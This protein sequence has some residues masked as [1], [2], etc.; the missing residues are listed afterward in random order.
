MMANPPI[1]LLEHDYA[2]SD[3]IIRD[4]EAL[5]ERAK[6]RQLR[7]LMVVSIDRAFASRPIV[8]CENPREMLGALAEA[9]H[10]LLKHY[11]DENDDVG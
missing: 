5:L 2:V 8:S 1:K 3:A 10:M 9:Q 4:L 11:C 7:G 6:N